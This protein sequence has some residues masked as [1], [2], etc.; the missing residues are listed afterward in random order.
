MLP[1]YSPK[2]VNIA[3]NGIAIQ[4]FAPDSFLRLRRNSD[5]LTETVGAAGE[6]G[7]TKIADRTGEIEIELMQTAESNLLLSA[8]A[9]ATENGG[10]ITTGVLMIQDP[11]GSVLA[12]AI[13]AYLK[14][15]PEIE[16]GV[17]Q[18]SKTWVFGCEV[19]EYTSTPAGF[20]AG[21]TGTTGQ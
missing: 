21:T 1:A 13:N 20:T 4:G 6:L 16:L 17:D 19:L 14:S 18:N 7:L 5:L 15:L 3:F 10:P 12:L 2:D 11:S 8:I 9:I